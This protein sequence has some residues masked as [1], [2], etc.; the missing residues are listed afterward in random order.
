[1]YW[2][3]LID[4]IVTSIVVFFGMLSFVALMM[5]IEVARKKDAD[6]VTPFVITFISGAF[7]AVLQTAL[8]RQIG[9]NQ[10]LWPIYTSALFFWL[11]VIAAVMIVKCFEMCVDDELMVFEKCFAYLLAVVCLSVA[12]GFLYNSIAIWDQ[13]VLTLTTE[14]CWPI[15]IATFLALWFLFKEIIIPNYINSDWQKI[16]QKKGVYK[17]G[18]VS[19][20]LGTI[21]D[22]LYLAYRAVS[23]RFPN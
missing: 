22:G 2:G 16:E 8:A 15:V 18:I 9:E 10:A 17:P 21:L 5:T 1:M 3:W 4:L 6:W 20:I 23:S 7:A 11:A 13:R 12:C 19:T 14:H